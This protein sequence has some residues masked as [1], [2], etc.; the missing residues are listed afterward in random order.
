MAGDELE[1][2][3]AEWGKHL[4]ETRADPR[5][6]LALL[7]SETLKYRDTLKRET[8][9][10]LTVADTRRA[11]DAL[12]RYLIGEA[13]PDTLTVEQN[14]LLQKWIEKLTAFSS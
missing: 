1:A 2:W 10:I 12:Q 6:T 14:T 9:K 11:L 7:I 5:G 8:G 13:V 4:F 3:F